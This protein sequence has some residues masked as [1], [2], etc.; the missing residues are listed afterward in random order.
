MSSITTAQSYEATVNHHGHPTGPVR[1]PLVDRQMFID[2]FNHRYRSA[3]FSISGY[4]A[5]DGTMSPLSEAFASI[6]ETKNNDP[7]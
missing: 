1:L 6:V 4:V 3:G 2:S 5:A 7:Q